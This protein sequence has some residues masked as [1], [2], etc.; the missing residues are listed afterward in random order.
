V[1]DVCFRADS[2]NPNQYANELGSTR[3]HIEFSAD[4][5]GADGLR[6][7]GVIDHYAKF[8]GEPE[9]YGSGV[10][11]KLA[12]DRIDN[13]N[14]GNTKL[15][16]AKLDL[17]KRD[18]PTFNNDRI[19]HGRLDCCRLDDGRGAKLSRRVDGCQLRRHSE[20]DAAG[21]ELWIGAFSGCHP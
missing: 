2:A 6:S 12:D 7:D 3:Q 17:A 18:D 13:A 8:Y 19:K 15:Y 21:R 1:C 11:A 16:H 5:L 14:F 4:H 10:T 9:L 20:Q